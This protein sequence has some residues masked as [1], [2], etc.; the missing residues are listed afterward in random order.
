MTNGKQEK[1]AVDEFAFL[2]DLDKYKLDE[3]WLDQPK[4][5]HKYSQQLADVRSELDQAKARRDV[6]LA[7]VE[8]DVRKDPEKYQVSKVTEAS[9]KVTVLKDERCQK[10]NARVLRMKHRVDV[11]QAL[12]DSLH[13]R[14]KSIEK[15]VDLWLADYWAEPR[16]PKSLPNDKLDDMKMAARRRRTHQST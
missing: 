4:Y 9:V 16:V 14:R 15:L 1:P 6:V 10:M 11:L 3:A 13:D 2:F 8:L 7:E 12:V 5:M